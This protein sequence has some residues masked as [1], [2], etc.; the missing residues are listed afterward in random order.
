MSGWGA[1]KFIRDFLSNTNF[2]NYNLK[3]ARNINFVCPKIE[4]I[5]DKITENP[6]W[7]DGAKLNINIY[8]MIKTT[9]DF[10]KKEKNKLERTIKKIV[11][12]MN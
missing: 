2:N 11:E 8:A 9:L 12:E 1:N 3:L 10:I 5:S 4:F 7:I 6:N